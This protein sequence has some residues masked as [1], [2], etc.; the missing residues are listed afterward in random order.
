MDDQNNKQRENK[1]L[2]ILLKVQSPFWMYDVHMPILSSDFLHYPSLLN[3]LR[4][5]TKVESSLAR[6][7]E[8][9]LL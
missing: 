4:L 1:S 3:L 9:T 6:V 5:I 2:F 8:G 7:G